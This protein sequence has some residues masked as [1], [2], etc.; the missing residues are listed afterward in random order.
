MTLS[1]HLDEFY[2]QYNIPPNGGVNDKVFEVPLPFFKLKLPNLSWR[3][4]MLYIHDLEHILNQQDVSWKGEMFIASWEISTGFWKNF[5][6]I[7]FPLWT[8]GWGLWKH[9]SSVYKGFRKGHSD[10]GIA[11]LNINKEKL[12]TMNLSQL[13]VLTQGKRTDPS[14][15]LLVIR[16][17]FWTLIS[18]IVF[19][20]PVFLLVSLFVVALH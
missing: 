5:P 12:L 17:F 1:D 20:T 16:L 7:L 3:R 4:K 19:L 10:R 11:G 15:S 13:K 8:M 9:P 2:E 6:V 14:Q 18:Q